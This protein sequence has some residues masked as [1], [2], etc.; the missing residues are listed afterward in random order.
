MAKKE[1]GK[2][3]VAFEFIEE[4]VLDLVLM[5]K[6]IPLVKQY[7]GKNCEFCVLLETLGSNHNYDQEKMSMFLEKQ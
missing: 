4:Q 7:Y 1:L 3:L 6:L 2:T 5:E